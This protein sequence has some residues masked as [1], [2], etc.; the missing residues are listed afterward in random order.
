MTSESHAVDRLLEPI[1]T[2]EWTGPDENPR[3]EQRIKEHRM[4]SKKFH[5]GR[6]G[7]ALIALGT[8]GGGALATVVTHQILTHR[9]VLVTDDGKMYEGDIVPEG[10]HG[11]ARFVTEDGSVYE[12]QLDE[13]GDGQKQI[14]VDV[15]G[16]RDGGGTITVE[17]IDD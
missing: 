8:L 6:T 9:A 13:S 11:N 12:L 4:N 17:D 1:A 15:T 14:T 10:G 7:I 2:T 5:L 16:D 3:V